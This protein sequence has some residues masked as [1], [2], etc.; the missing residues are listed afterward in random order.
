M[1]S[2][3]LW[4]DMP[5]V[6]IAFLVVSSMI[7][8]FF[9]R[10]PMHKMIQALS[11]A[12]AGGLRKLAVWTQKTAQAVREKDRKVI[13]ESGVA[14]IQGEILQ[15]FSKIDIANTKTLTGY[16][17]LQL[18]LDDSISQI[19]RD[20]KECG[21]VTP[22]APGWSEVIESIARAQGSTGDRI[23]ENMLAEIHKSA[24]AGEKKALSEFRD[25][26]AKRHKILGTIAPVW[27]RIEKTGKEV[28]KQVDRVI[29]NSR[30]MEKYMD[31][32]QKISSGAPESVD[33]LSSK[34][35]KLFIISLIVLFIGLVGAFVNFNLIALPMSELVP[36]GARVAGLAVSEISAL[37]IVAL[38]LMLGIFL[39]EAI[40]VTHIFP[41]I[42]N[43][44]RGKRKIIL[45]GSLFGLLF[46]SLVEASLAILRD[47]L[48]EAKTA[49]DISLAGGV[50][51]VAESFTSNI[52]VIGQAT[53]GFVLPWIL[54]VMAIPLEMFIESSQHV[55]ARL[56]T[57]LINLLCHLA[58]GIAYLIE[59]LFKILIHVF[60]IYIIVPLQIYNM[61]KGKPISAG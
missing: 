47:N 20:Y 8:L 33:L 5:G 15:E 38:E 48:A 13:L 55:L 49:L 31:Q 17:K 30:N 45:Y 41:Q 43:M 51:A 7:F 18:K 2:F 1:E 29:E 28:G 42:A 56:Y 50:A 16:P 39:F 46:L 61:F 37:V 54:A 53:L 52:T 59:G 27:K 32:Y 3:Y 10:D 12:T 19:E 36:A 44:T 21:Q 34:V 6:S 9:A 4:P 60:D 25:V 24:V 58:N 26:A 22:A 11:D 35:T 57:M 40:G 23:I 14:K